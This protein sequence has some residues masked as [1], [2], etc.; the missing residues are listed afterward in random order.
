MRVTR[1]RPGLDRGWLCAAEVWMRGPF[2]ERE[3]P[4]QTFW[5]F[6]R[7]CR[8]VGNTLEEMSRVRQ[9]PFL[10][11]IPVPVCRPS[12]YSALATIT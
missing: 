10:V 6:C 8:L 1:V 3:G 9:A 2:C 7:A 12:R 11:D 5:T 4:V